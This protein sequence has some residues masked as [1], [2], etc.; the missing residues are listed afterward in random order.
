MTGLMRLLLTD[1]YRSADN[2]EHAA[3]RN[4]WWRDDVQTGIAIEDATVWRPE[5]SDKR[6]AII[7]RR[8]TWKS[9]KVAIDNLSGTT[10]TGFDEHTK[11]WRGSHTLFCIAKEGA[12]AEILAAETYRYL[13]HFGPVFRKYFNLMMFELVEV[14]GLSELEEATE[15]YAVPITVA[16]GWGETWVLQLLSPR[17]KHISLSSLFP[18]TAYEISEP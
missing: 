13:L 4:R 8:N 7:I 18:P 3:F 6:P 1:H 11:L 10:P 17:L 15:R 9:I 2:I 14:G 16:Y 12:E 5:L